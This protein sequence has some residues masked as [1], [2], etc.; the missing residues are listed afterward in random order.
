MH[1]LH[2]VRSRA[3]KLRVRSVRRALKK[4]HAPKTLHV[5]NGG[6]LP[7]RALQRE[8]RARPKIAPLI[9]ARR[10]N[11][12]LKYFEGVIARL[13]HVHLSLISPAQA[14]QSDACAK[15]LC[16]HVRVQHAS[17]SSDPKRPIS[18]PSL[19]LDANRA[20]CAAHRLGK[21]GDAKHVIVGLLRCVLHA[22]HGWER[23]S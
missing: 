22:L 7:A 1:K 18:T 3:V 15:M 2:A 17:N 8:N 9:H 21:S 14:H 16:A 10:T 6:A 20:L 5:T 13:K 4:H 23:F 11:V 12:H 19:R